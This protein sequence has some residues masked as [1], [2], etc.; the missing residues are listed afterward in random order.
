M[1][2]RVGRVGTGGTLD[3]TATPSQ[4]ERGPRNEDGLEP[5]HERI[6]KASLM[7]KSGGYYYTLYIMN[8]YYYI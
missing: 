8:Y 2:V 5:F 6:S 3:P 7:L 4:T 1:L